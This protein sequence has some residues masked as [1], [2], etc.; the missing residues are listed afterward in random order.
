MGNLSGP[1]ILSE[2]D[3]YQ[4]F[5]AV[6]SGYM[7]GQYVQ[8]PN[9]TGYRL[10]LSGGTL[11][12]GNL[13]QS[14]ADDTQ[15]NSMTVPATVAA[16]TKQE[17]GVTITNGTTAV[18]ANQFDGGFLL[19]SVTP[20][21]G[22]SYGITGHGTATNGSSWKLYLDRP[23]RTAWTTSTKVTVK[24]NPYSG[25]IQFPATTQTGIP[26]GACIY[27]ITSAYYGFVQTHGMA[28]LLSDGSTFAVGSE[29]GTP[30][31]TA[32]CVTVFAA[33]TTHTAVGYALSAADSGKCIPVFLQ[34]D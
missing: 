23:I 34:I 11:T 4:Q 13:L 26:A 1:A 25:V 24:R 28:S 33:G 15:F 7:I 6:P 8:G 2:V 14:A 21:L 3:L 5:S 29:V 31:G 16:G 9:G 18:T 12:V 30:S 27:A 17:T 20:G 10:A 32:G 19:V 22:E